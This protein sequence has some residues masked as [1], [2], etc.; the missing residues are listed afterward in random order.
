MHSC[1]RLA[2]SRVTAM[3]TADEVTCQFQQYGGRLC[4]SLWSRTSPL[5]EP[6]RELWPLEKDTSCPH[7][8]WPVSQLL[9][10]GASLLEGGS[11]DRTRREAA[12]ASVCVTTESTRGKGVG[13]RLILGA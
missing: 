10:E 2:D 12:R 6:S 1:Q 11:M 9:G 13:T 3:R 8:P 7:L 4:S 5:E